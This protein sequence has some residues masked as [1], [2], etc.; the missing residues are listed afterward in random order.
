MDEL[1]QERSR[2]AETISALET[3]ICESEAACGRMLQRY[4]EL[5]RA[6]TL[7]EKQIQDDKENLRRVQHVKEDKGRELDVVLTK[8]S[9]LVSGAENVP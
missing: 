2:Y 3:Q 8:I 7:R 6:I 5:G 1:R 4:L 9:N